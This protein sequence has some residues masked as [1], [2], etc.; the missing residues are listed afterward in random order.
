VKVLVTGGGGFLGTGIVR[1]MRARGVSV[2]VLG[3]S[4]YPALERE[5]IECVRGDVRDPEAVRRASE[6]V[7][8]IFHVASRVGYWG[9]KREYVETN[10]VGTE[11]LLSAAK[12][13]GVRRFVY[14]STPSVV[15]GTRGDLKAADETLPYPPKHLTYYAETKAAAEARVLAANSAELG[16][17]AIR[18]HFIFGPG[19]PQIVP[20]LIERANNGTLVRIGRGENKVDVSYID[21]VVEAH[22][23]AHDALASPSSAARG[24][25]YFIGQ[26]KPVLLWDFIAR[27]LAG[28]GAP[29]VKKHLSLPLARVLGAA[30]ETAYRV[31]GL[32]G[33]P[34]ITRSVAMIMG[35]SHYFSHEKARRD[36][37]YEPKISVEE[38]LARVFE[39]GLHRDP[40][41]A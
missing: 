9:P 3:R 11:I 24:Q 41:S 14:T 39:A 28:F 22:V 16:T 6:G 17:A 15:I 27:V 13:A 5:G 26:E 19:D 32:K 20:R 18:P 34:R 4:N 2:R 7:E 23:L 21:N 30:V 25:A 10:I 37:G 33:E 38:G 29:P 36:F 12:R 40:A 1:A 35:T 31:L 8:S